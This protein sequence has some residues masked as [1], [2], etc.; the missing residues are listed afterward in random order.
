[1]KDIHIIQFFMYF[2]IVILKIQNNFNH[3]YK[4]LMKQNIKSVNMLKLYSQIVSKIKV[5]F[6]VL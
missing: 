4:L 1:M 6:M 2:I 5:N 3:S